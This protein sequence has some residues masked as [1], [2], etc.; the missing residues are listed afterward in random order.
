MILTTGDV[1]VDPALSQVSI[2]YANDSFIADQI[3]PVLKVS[4]MTGKYFVY[5]KSN[6]RVDKTQRALGSPS[7]EVD[8][9]V[10]PSGS[11][12]CNDH[13][14]KGFIPDQIQDQADAAIN[15][16]VDEA[17]Y[18]TEKLLID[19]E[20]ALANLI[21]NTSNV[22]QNVT[23]TGSAQWSDYTNSDPIGDV[24]TARTTIHQNTFKKPNTLVLG[25]QVFDMLVEHPQIIE[26][27]K[28]SQ[29]GV[30]S[31]ELLARVF[32]V[33]RILVG[34]TGQNTAKEGQT[35]ALAY[36]WGKNAIV[37]FV[38]PQIRL[39]TLTFGWTFTY[40]LRQAKKWRDED[41][42]GTYVRIGNDNYIQ[43]IVAV[44]AGYLI[45]TCIA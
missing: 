45:A 11:Y 27:I 17:E 37:C 33:D 41:R 39:K 16:L 26:R 30:V 12:S 5:D 3:F 13:A 29:L 14:L 40:G 4:T 10:T 19:R 8:F 2:K 7:N 44:N 21:T 35:D 9:G 1:Y 15:P 20:L 24:R 25:K 22:T 36:V 43:S 31:L 18:I 6:L 42:E 28:Y 34:E 23:L 32:Q 38:S